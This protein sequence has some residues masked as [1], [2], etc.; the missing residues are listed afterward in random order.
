MKI[1]V[2]TVKSRTLEERGDGINF[3]FDFRHQLL[4]DCNIGYL[5]LYQIS[6]PELM[7]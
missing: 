4:L 3:Y 7:P 6:D 2:H 1:N 5:D